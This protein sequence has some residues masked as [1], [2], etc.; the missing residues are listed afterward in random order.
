MRLKQWLRGSAL[1]AAGA[2]AGMLIMQPAASSQ[3]KI[4]GMRLHHIGLYVKNMEESKEFYTKKLGLREAFTFKD[5]Q[6]HPIDYFYI[7][8]DTFLE[9]TAADAQ[10]PA[11]F[12]HAGLWVDD[13][14]PTVKSLQQ[15]GVNVEDVHLGMTK[16]RIANMYDQNGVRFE[17]SAYPPESLQAIAM[18]PGK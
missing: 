5:E 2:I 4:A 16:A 6:G 9:I 8:H 12:G 1:F 7:S 3:K 17:L 15:K 11:G 14:V 18:A 13:L 10:H